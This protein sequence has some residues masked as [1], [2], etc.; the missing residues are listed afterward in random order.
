MGRDQL[1][2]FGEGGFIFSDGFIYSFRL[3]VE[4]RQTGI[5]LEDGVIQCDR[6]FECGFR[7]IIF[8]GRGEQLAQQVIDKRVLGDQLTMLPDAITRFC[9]LALADLDCRNLCEWI[10]EIGI[11]LECL[12]EMRQG[13]GIVLVEARNHAQAVVSE[14]MVRYGLGD[15][16]E[17][18]A[19]FCGIVFPQSRPPP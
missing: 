5:G 4:P 19:G 6:L 13:I 2:V 9:R 12:L 18:L 17:H 7:L 11:G 15:R 16:F 3:Y 8:H 14:R 10:Y 1:G